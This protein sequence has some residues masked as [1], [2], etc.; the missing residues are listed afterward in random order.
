MR[1]VLEYGLKSPTTVV[2]IVNDFSPIQVR[3]R[4]W[5]LGLL[6]DNKGTY[7]TRARCWTVGKTGGGSAKSSHNFVKVMA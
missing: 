3:N 2:T 7:A 1:L 6:I 5:F 4:D